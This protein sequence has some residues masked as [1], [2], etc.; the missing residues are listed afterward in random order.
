[1][2]RL[3]AARI[4]TRHTHGTG[5][6]FSAAITAGLARRVEILHA[7]RDAKTFITAA[8]REGFPLGSGHGPANPM[9]TLIRTAP[10]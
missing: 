2:V 6:V 3:E 10:G 7:I 1:V 9:H 5:C 4:E 8:I